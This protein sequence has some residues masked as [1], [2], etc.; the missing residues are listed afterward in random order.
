MSAAL[1]E[2]LHG[3][4]D[5]GCCEGVDA[6]VPVEVLNRPGL[7]AV[8]YRVGT[9][10]TFRESLLAR[11][12]GTEVPPLQSL[13][14]RADDWTP[15]LLDAWAVV[16]DVLTFYQERI[17]NEQYLRTATERRSVL[18]LARAI[19]YELAPGAAASTALAFTLEDAPG[20]PAEVVIG[21]GTRAQSVPG[22][23]EK[24]QTFETVEE[25]AARPGWNALVPRRTRPQAIGKTTAGVWVRSAAAAVQKGDWVMLEQGTTWDL[26]AVA[27][28]VRDGPGDR[29]YLAFSEKTKNDY[30]GTPGLFVFRQVA[31]LFGHNAPDYRLLPKEA[32]TLF[33]STATVDATKTGWAAF[34]TY[35]LNPKSVDLDAVYPKI[36]P[37]SWIVLRTSTKQTRFVADSVQE[38]SRAD[39]ALSARI[40]RIVPKAGQEPVATDFP[41]NGTAVLAQ[42]EALP[43]ADMDVVEPV[44]GDDVELGA[45]MEPF[46]GPRTVIV[47]GRA[48]RLTVAPA[49]AP[50]T[51]VP[52]R[53]GAPEVTLSADDSLLLL[54]APRDKASSWILDVRDAHGT[55]GTVTALP[56][57]VAWHPALADDP[58]LAE[59][60]LVDEVQAADPAHPVLKLHVPLTHA[61]DRATCTVAANVAAAT[62]G[63]GVA[64]ALGSGNAAAE[65]PRFALRQ[66]PLT[67]VPQP[68]V[69]SGVESTL[70]V[71][72][73]ELKWHEVPTLYGRR[74]HERVFT[75][76]RQ[77]D[78]TTLVQFG[79]GRTG[80]RLPTG[81]ENVRAAYRKGIGPEG[82]LRAGQLSLLMTRALGLRSV[83]NPIAATGGQAPQEMA[84]A[85]ENAPLTLLTLGRVV[86]LRDYRDFARGYAG[87]GKAHVVWTWDAGTR[88]VYV[89]VAGVDGAAVPAGSDPQTGLL[90]ALATFGDAG[91]PAR[92]V[93]YRSV[94]F[95]VKAVVHCHPDYL[96]ARVK[97]AVEAA[98]A[99]RFGFHAQKFGERVA[100]SQVE[101]VMQGVPGVAWVEVTALHR[102]D[103]GAV[104]RQPWLP[105]DAPETGGEAGDLLPAELL[106]LEL[107]PDDIVAEIP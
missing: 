28:V 69:P 29:S 92:V 54:A 19:G 90:S 101:A 102:D 74:P 46:G 9:W 104:T 61:Y 36:L 38:A 106:T 72:V 62:H 94:P 86:S 15:A 31:G 27:D 43:L 107:R 17:A 33:E 103:A 83:V 4:D 45:K 64:E 91:V 32:R 71:R 57:S 66:P 20:A 18:E 89:T 42:A 25:V 93:S 95:H 81:R 87:I 12:S 63:E 24:P 13:T 40:T 48:P 56:S 77:D 23:G 99:A 50:A 73:D 26:L 16:G 3:L 55:V 34:S 65:W 7:P 49:A 2:S 70:E 6:A 80:A 67:Y 59:T 52:A 82:N 85:R 1:D 22:P 30:T 88:G 14:A 68:A 78:G 100:L 75:T 39:F 58:E 5:C 11:L 76:R 53:K 10:Q 8:A 98:L 96:P 47:R 105:A 84:D 41:L 37:G 35:V 60:A 21:E 97:A 44:M 79:D 51:L